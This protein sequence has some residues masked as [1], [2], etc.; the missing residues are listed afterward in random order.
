MLRHRPRG[1]RYRGNPLLQFNVWDDLKTLGTGGAAALGIGKIWSYR[2]KPKMAF[3]RNNIRNPLSQYSGRRNRDFTE[4]IA[5]RRAIAQAIMQGRR[6]SRLR[7]RRFKPV[8]Y[9]GSKRTFTYKNDG[10]SGQKKYVR[11]RKRRRRKMSLKKKV[12]RMARN[13][14]KMSTKTFRDF[15]TLTMSATTANRKKV[16]WI[17]MFDHPNYESYI[18][19]LTGVDT[20]SNVDYRASNTSV[21]MDLF[22]R[23]KCK[24]N[25]T[26]NTKIR[27]AI[28]ACKDDDN[29]SPLTQIKEELEARGYTVPAVQSAVASTATSSRVPQRI[30]FQEGSF[31]LPIF[32]NQQLLKNWKIVQGVKTS[33]IGPGDTFNCA[34]SKRNHIYKPETLDNEPFTYL[35]GQSFGVLIEFSGDISHDQTNTGKI[36][37]GLWHIDGEEQRQAHVKYANPKGLKEVVYTDDLTATNFTVPTHADNEASAM[38]IGDT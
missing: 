11:K 14:P 21:K 13:M 24:S 7:Y 3:P 32:S 8:S 35:S 33:T 34:W 4:S 23:L 18:Q 28:L 2:S 16:Y 17:N 20:S 38:E 26:A 30:T 22:Y 15:R 29:E 19:N 31:H 6:N 12:N 36:G 5:R 27:Y 25:I 10:V 1:G 9:A 37:Y